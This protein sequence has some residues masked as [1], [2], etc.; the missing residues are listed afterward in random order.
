MSSHLEVI[1]ILFFIVSDARQLRSVESVASSCVGVVKTV[2][3]FLEKAKVLIGTI[4]VYTKTEQYMAAR[5]GWISINAKQAL[6][7]GGPKPLD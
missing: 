3:C 4:H 2:S 6:A 1:W 5:Q 7:P